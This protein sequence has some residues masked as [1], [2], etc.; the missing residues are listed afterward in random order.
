MEKKIKKPVY[1][2]E[3]QQK[4]KSFI[5]CIDANS[6]TFMVQHMLHEHSDIFLP[7]LVVGEVQL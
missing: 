7:M 2:L 4:A 3:E 5:E 1:S 6:L